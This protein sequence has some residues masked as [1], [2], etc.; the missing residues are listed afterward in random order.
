MLSDLI[1]VV[2][3]VST[4]CAFAALRT[5]GSIVAWGEPRHGGLPDQNSNAVYDWENGEP[6]SVPTKHGFSALHGSGAVKQWP[7]PSNYWHSIE[8]DW[9][10]G[11]SWP[12]SADCDILAHSIPAQM[13]PA[14]DIITNDCGWMIIYDDA[15]T[16]EWAYRISGSPFYGVVT[17]G[18]YLFS[19][20]ETVN[21]YPDKVDYSPIDEV[22]TNRYGFAVLFQDGTYLIQ[23][24]ALFGGDGP[25]NS[26]Q[27]VEAFFA[28]DAAFVA[29]DETGKLHR[30]GPEVY[31]EDT[32]NDMLNP[33]RCVEDGTYQSFWSEREA[34]PNI[35]TTDVCP[36][37]T[38][39]MRG[40][41]ADV[42]TGYRTF[43]MSMDM[44]T[45]TCTYNEC[46]LPPTIVQF[47]SN[48]DDCDDLEASIYLGAT[49]D[50]ATP[51]DESCTTQINSQT[52]SVQLN[53]ETSQSNNAMLLMMLMLGLSWLGVALKRKV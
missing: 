51:Y 36:V 10:F 17:T 40:G 33:P 42:H 14:V 52:A 28:T 18:N 24:D 31:G 19:M 22:T 13:P 16:D 9:G 11:S 25:A 47:S 6:L 46:G 27:D 23:G 32:T 50:P 21:Q 26:I 43:I 41:V 34:T 20:Y 4:D 2:E 53:L 30:W 39:A 49:D 7:A 45:G 29:L 8:W 1:N 48:D 44:S 3:I 15:A 37:D 12:R 38:I 35:A 5:D